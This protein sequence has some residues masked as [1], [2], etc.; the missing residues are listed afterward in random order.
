MINAGD[1][2]QG[3]R[4]LVLGGSGGIGAEI[5]RYLARAG[6]DIVIHGGHDEGKLSKL[7]A[8]LSECS[9]RLSTV[10]RELN[11]ASDAARWAG[12]YEDIDILVVAF[13]PFLFA[14]LEDTSPEEWERMALLNLALPGALVS[15]F[16]PR[17]TRHGY[18][19]ILL[20]GGTDTDLPQSFRKVAA[21]SAAKSGLSTLARSAAAAYG[22]FGVTVNVLCPGPVQTEY[23]SES[24]KLYYQRILADNQMMEPSTLVP[25][26][27]LL[28]SQP[29]A[30]VNGVTIRVD[31]G[32]DRRS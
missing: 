28:L 27:S 3:L 17:M 23:Q 21:Y 31:K 19:R 32:W 14:G 9:G 26:V 12:S 25:L 16:A 6:A 13:G 20:F 18:G 5:S 8:E 10:L 22:P 1:S 24:E 4:A 7:R 11:N 15:T 2:F 30:A 29:G